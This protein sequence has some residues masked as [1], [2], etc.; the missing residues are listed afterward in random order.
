MR[1]ANYFYLIRITEP[2]C[3]ISLGGSVSKMCAVCRWLYN[4]SAIAI[5]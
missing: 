3:I 5:V 1:I 4:I 2:L